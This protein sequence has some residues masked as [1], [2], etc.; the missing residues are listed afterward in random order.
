MIEAFNAA[1]SDQE[2]SAAMQ[3]VAKTDGSRSSAKHP[4]LKL[5]KRQKAFGI[6]NPTESDTYD[7]AEK[8]KHVASSMPVIRDLASRLAILR[9]PSTISA[10]A[11]VSDARLLHGLRLPLPQL[12]QKACGRQGFDACQRTAVEG[13]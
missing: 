4:I 11:G 8:S 2:H 13:P 3:L 12:T 7:A 6:W 1:K 5:R 10:G 9:P